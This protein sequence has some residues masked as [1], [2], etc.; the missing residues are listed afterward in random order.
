MPEIGVPQDSEKLPFLW[1]AFYSAL[2]SIATALTQSGTTAQ[3]PIVFLW[4]GRP[5][6]DTTL[7]LAIWVKSVNPIVWVR[8]DG[9]AV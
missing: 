4:V 6:F 9:G 7:G 3:R 2:A 8:G 1:R 5:Y